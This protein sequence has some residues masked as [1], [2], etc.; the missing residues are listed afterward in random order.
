MRLSCLYHESF[1][2]HP[3]PSPLPTGRQASKGE[4]AAVQSRHNDA[5]VSTETMAPDGGGGQDEDLLGPPP[6]EGRGDFLKKMSNQL[7]TPL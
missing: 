1:S 7:W 3:T 4:G 2:P 6:T 5:K